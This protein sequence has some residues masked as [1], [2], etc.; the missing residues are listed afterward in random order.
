MILARL[1]Y[2]HRNSESDAINKNCEDTRESTLHNS[3]ML[4]IS[5]KMMCRLFFT[6]LL[7]F[8]VENFARLTR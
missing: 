8:T 3:N 7:L 2:S 6:Q 4:K 5:Y 1:L